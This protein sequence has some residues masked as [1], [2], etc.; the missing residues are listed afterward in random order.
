MTDAEMVAEIAAKLTT[1]QREVILTHEHP[2][3]WRWYR[4]SSRVAGGWW[5]AGRPLMDLNILAWHP[6]PRQT[7][8]SLTPIGL[9]VRAHLE[10]GGRE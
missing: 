1:A 5:Q 9:A 4:L 3:D 7:A 8:T 10:A 2:Y 6:N